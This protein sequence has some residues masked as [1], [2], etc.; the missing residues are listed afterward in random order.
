MQTGATIL[1]IASFGM[2]FVSMIATIIGVLDWD[3]RLSNHLNATEQSSVFT[4]GLDVNQFDADI[5]PSNLPKVFALA[6]GAGAQ[7]IRFSPGGGWSAI[8]PSDGSFSWT[9]FDNSIAQAAANSL[10][11][12]LEMGNEPSWD[13]YGGN[14]NAPP[15][16]CWGWSP[17]SPSTWCSSVA[18][19]IGASNPSSGLLYHL[20]ST[21]VTGNPSETEIQVI[22]G[23]IPRNEPQVYTR[24]WV[25]PANGGPAQWALDYAHFEQV[26]YSS[27]HQAV[28]TFNSTHGTNYSITVMTG[29]E[30]LSSFELARLSR[31]YSSPSDLAFQANESAFETT[32]FSTPAFCDNVDEVDIHVSDHGPM[33]SLAHVDLTE[34]ALKACDGGHFIPIFVSE[35]GFSSDTQVQTLAQYQGTLPGEYLTGQVGQAR[36]LYDTL[37]ALKT[38]PNVVGAS[39]TFVVDSNTTDFFPFGSL[40]STRDTG[41]GSGM[42][43]ANG[44][45]A[46]VP[47]ESLSAYEALSQLAP[48]PPPPSVPFTNPASYTFF[49][50][51]DAVS[52]PTSGTCFAVAE[53]STILAASLPSGF[54]EKTSIPTSGVLTSISCP[55][56]SLCL[57][58]GQD[59]AGH[60]VIYRTTNGGSAFSSVYTGPSVSMIVSLSCPDQN[61]CVAVGRA[62]SDLLVVVSTNGG[63][64]FS[65][66]TTPYGADVLS[67][68]CASSSLCLLVGQDS[69]LSPAVW[70]TTNMGA[71]YSQTNPSTG[72]EGVTTSV[73]CVPG[74][75]TCYASGISSRSG[76]FL[77]ES[78]DGGSTWVQIQP[79]AGLLDLSS[80][81][82]P[83]L[84]LCY[85]TADTSQASGVVSISGSTTSF[86]AAPTTV[87]ALVN[88]DCADT[89]D[90]VAVGSGT[91]AVFAMIGGSNFSAAPPSTNFN[92]LTGI[93][94]PSA[95]VVTGESS[96][97][98]AIWQIGAGAPTPAALP[99]GVADVF[100][101]SC[102]STSLCVAA[103]DTTSSAVALIS[104]DSGAH[105]S[106]GGSFPAG[107]AITSISCPSTTLCYA[108]GFSLNGLTPTAELFS[109][110]DGG[111]TFS[112]VSLSLGASLL[113]SVACS[114]TSV[115][116]ASGESFSSSGDSPLVLYLSGNSWKQSSVPPSTSSNV[117]STYCTS[118]ECI[119]GTD[120][121]AQVIISPN[122]GASF[123]APSEVPVDGVST[124]SCNT[125]QVC[126]LGAHGDQLIL[127][128]TNG[129]SSF[130]ALASPFEGGICVG[131]ATSASGFEATGYASILALPATPS[132][133]PSVT[134]VSPDAS[135]TAGGGTVSING[136]GFSTATA[137]SFGSV[138][139]SFTIVSDTEITAVVPAQ[140]AGVV[141][142]TVTNAQGSSA[143]WPG[144]R[145]L[146]S[147]PSQFVP[148][149]PFRLADTR[150]GTGEPYSG[151][152]LAPFSTLTIQVAGAS[153][154][155]SGI[156]ANAQAV[157][158]NVTVV[159]PQDPGYLTIWPAGL[160]QPLSS[161]INFP[162][163]AIKAA[164]SQIS[165]GQGG[166]VSIFNGSAGSVDVVVD[167]YGYFS[168]SGQGGF[169]SVSPYRLAD[170]RPGTHTPYS[171]MTLSSGGS[172]KIQVSGVDGVP[173][174]AVAAVVNVTGTDATANGDYF[175]V[176][177]SDAPSVP[178]SSL[179]NLGPNITIA[180]RVAVALSSTGAISVYNFTGNAD[181]VIDLVGYYVS[182]G[183]HSFVAIQP[184]RVCD[185]RQG[186]PANQCSGKTLSPGSVLTF[187]PLT[188]SSGVPSTA[189]AVAIEATATNTTAWSYMTVW[190]GGTMPL[191][192][193]LNWSS[194]VTNS[195]LTLPSVSSQTTVSAY[196][197][198]GTADF[199]F[200]V[201]GYYQ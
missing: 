154:G 144:D 2:V 108:V 36:F 48:A 49:S 192:S 162:P 152:T 179:L 165:V 46:Y 57:V 47:K 112:Q 42:L 97:S 122:G 131:L 61:N 98:G 128:S 54:S 83:S 181:A 89:S 30:E 95:C 117:M 175:T 193:D 78:T 171:G 55:T 147:A 157:A 50:A 164:Y 62:G 114:S 150:S 166:Q 34:D 101:I 69:Q 177:P 90:C 8:E 197:A 123:S 85:G 110:T 137:V 118:L 60:A 100:A 153:S 44:A 41:T 67:S 140:G 11:V 198:F 1:K 70:I 25:D 130:S 53:P 170:T 126:Y 77:A 84:S 103:A 188:A 93:S 52:C 169:V 28:S 35:S 180:N 18:Q 185:T 127:A 109:S 167:A 22:A 65:S 125:N 113:R 121:Q 196:N 72:G 136:S 139:A 13:A 32:L 29:G 133:V 161:T 129:G 200:D 16:D 159:A 75:T 111:M 99:S 183:G 107:V 5:T 6:K 27:A 45:G 87:A 151:Q 51:I 195:N 199:L 71:S 106:F 182:S 132:L 68:S 63:A 148:I 178:L 158:L 40:Y 43:S 39:W 56:T 190:A 4:L 88:L 81:S 91:T 124:I 66:V 119:A 187:S 82:C 138:A 80:L 104:T 172:L 201:V 105:F 79:P 143:T 23:L 86:I 38:D 26:V 17:S 134:S 3:T 184:N 24:N 73:S 173:A 149:V 155:S 14:T 59:Y 96:R 141:D 189:Y 12:F 116:V 76:V 92:E 21:P 163:K 194:G 156:A 120:S 19:W 168:T 7:V 142:V 10:K 15:K 33:F 58:A 174:G 20:M 146:Y 191:A 176:Y 74:T 145:F 186:A 160:P 135:S 9:S 102:P 94:C 64:G 115:C 37:S 31:P